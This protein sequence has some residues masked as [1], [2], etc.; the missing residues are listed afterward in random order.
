MK[1]ITLLIL[2]TTLV[3]AQEITLMSKSTILGVFKKQLLSPVC[4]DKTYKRKGIDQT[5]FLMA[6]GHK[7]FITRKQAKLYKKKRRGHYSM[8]CRYDQKAK[9]F[10]NC[11]IEK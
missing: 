4:H 9:V 3:Q 8:R 11:Y 10:H 1:L 2:L 6:D 5:C 7:L